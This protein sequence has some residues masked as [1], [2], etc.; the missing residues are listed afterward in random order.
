MTPSSVSSNLAIPASK[1]RY[2]F[3][4]VAIAVSLEN[5]IIKAVKIQGDFFGVKDVEEIENS[6]IGKRYDGAELKDSLDEKLIGECIAGMD[7]TTFI[8][9]LMS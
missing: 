5:G 7:K 4:G 8:E 1:K 3:G 6:I 2:P 9:L